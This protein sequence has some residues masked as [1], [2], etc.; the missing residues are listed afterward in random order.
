M[1]NN[2]N[3]TDPAGCQ[4]NFIVLIT[5]GGPEDDWS[6]NGDIKGMSWSG[7]LGVVAARTSLDVTQPDTATD[8]FEVSA[9]VPYGPQDLAGTLFD[10]GY[11]WL[12]ELT[13]FMAHADVSP[14]ARNLSGDGG[15]DSITGRQSVND[16][17]DRFRRRQLA[18][19]AERR[20]DA[21]T[22]SITPPTTVRRCRPRSFPR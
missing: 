5:D 10:N 3:T 7:S 9:G 18:R 12:D 6:A 8:Q 20:V 16:L 21:A 14:G 1:L 4:K 15:T 2:P 17:H 11:I 13:Y 19:I 22:A